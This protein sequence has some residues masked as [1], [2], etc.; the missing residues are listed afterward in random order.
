[1]TKI[2]FIIKYYFGKLG[3]DYNY[4]FSFDLL[5]RKLFYLNKLALH[6]V[7]LPIYYSHKNQYVF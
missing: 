2:H 6:L 3:I 4:H 5:G 1:M 7:S